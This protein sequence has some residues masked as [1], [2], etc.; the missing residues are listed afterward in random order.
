M[1]LVLPSRRRELA[2]ALV[3]LVLG[4]VV[5]LMAGSPSAD[6]RPG[7]STA[8][9]PDGT[10]GGLNKATGEYVLFKVRNRRVRDL[11]FNTRI[12]CQASDS[13]NAETRFFS[14][15][16]APDGR[17]I[18]ANGRLHLE[19][20]ER[21]DGRQGNIGVN[22]KFGVRDFADIAVIVPE[23]Q[24]PEAEPEEAKESCDGGAIVNFRRGFEV[25]PLPTN[26]DGSP[27]F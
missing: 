9:I 26:P 22:L 17:L 13:P 3:V 1:G 25:P 10:Y 18:P 24:G 15:V 27:A 23:E 2:A 20:Q 21:G 7:P 12:I 6:A 16:K 11:A 19:W 5:C 14:A 4:I 8:V